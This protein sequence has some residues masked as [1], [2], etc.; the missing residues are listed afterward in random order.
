MTIIIGLFILALVVVVIG[1]FVLTPETPADREHIASIAE[2]M[3]A[4]E[5]REEAEHQAEMKRKNVKAS[6]LHTGRKE[7]E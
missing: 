3:T 2:P 1:L 4:K 6:W 7:D 5:R